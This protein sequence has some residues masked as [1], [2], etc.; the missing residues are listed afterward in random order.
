MPALPPY[1]PDKQADFNNWA[2]NFASVINSSPSTFGLT[3]AD[4]AIISSAVANWNMAYSAVTAPGQKTQTTVQ[5]KNTAR[6]TAS[7]TLRNYSQTIANNAGVATSDK[8][9][10]GVNPRTSKPTPIT[11]PSTYPVLSVQAGA[12]RQPLREVSG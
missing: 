6:T 1:L 5:A 12:N 2:N 3:A 10:A 7:V 11:P 9:D 4:G 8:L